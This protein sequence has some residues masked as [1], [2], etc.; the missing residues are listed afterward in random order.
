MRLDKRYKIELLGRISPDKG[1]FESVKGVKSAE[2]NGEENYLSLSIE[3]RGL[4]SA[5]EIVREL[6]A[7]I[8][9]IGGDI[10][11]KEISRPL[12]NLNCAAC[13][14][15]AQ[16]TL[17]HLPGVIGASVNY[18]NGKANIKY[19]P[20]IV[21]PS[22]IKRVL[23]QMGYELLI[24]EG[25]ASFQNVEQIKEKGY[26]KLRR[27]TI[28]AALFAIPLVI[29]GMFLKDMAHA[30][31]IM[32]LLS[33]P[34][35]LF[36]GRRFFVGALKQAKNRTANMDTLVA[37]STGIA[38]LFSLFNMLCPQFWEQKGLEA[39]VYFEAA[40]VII[41]FILLGRLLEAKATGSTSDAI[42]KLM[43][44]QPS[45][46]VVLRDDNPVEIAISEVLV[47][48]VVLVKPGEK[49][50]LDG[51]VIE[52]GSFVDES[53][54][55]GEPIHVEKGVGDKVYAGTI[56]Q[57]GSFSFRAKKVGEETLLAQIIK[58]VDEA[59]SSKAP[60]QGMVDKIAAI[61]VPSVIIIALISFTVWAIF[62]GENGFVYGLLAMVTVL[63][64]A[65]PCAL[66]LAT[67]TAVMVGIGKGAEEGVLI[68]DAESLEM[69][70]DIDM[71]ILDKTGT[72][73]EGKPQVTSITWVA[74]ALPLYS[75]IL[76]SIEYRSEHPL[77]D[78]ICADLKENSTLLNDIFVEQVSGKGITGRYDETHYYIGN[79][80]YIA[81]KNISIPEELQKK[82]E[83][84]LEAAHTVSIFADEKEAFAV[85]AITDKIKPGSK[86]AIEQLRSDGI[87]LAIYTGDNEKV[88]VALARELGIT[89][90][91]GGVLP[92]EKSEMVKMFQQQGRKVAMV[93]DG[94]N[95]SA[96]LAQADVSIA[97]G[98]G[99]DIAMD[100]AKM[101]IISSDLKKIP[102][103]I[104]LSKLTVRTIRQNLFWAFI[105]N[106]IGIPI[107]AGIL[108]PLTGFLLNP[109]IA[110]AAMALSS[111]S[112][113]TNSLR[114]RRKKI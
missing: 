30:N 31:L 3:E 63:V 33:T 97:M 72:I 15:G 17:L 91:K 105:Y 46:V 43:G 110:G 16:N 92:E 9:K 93:G 44:L 42:K 82:I 98:A 35:L 68:K 60:V 64:I 73:T 50:A 32:F 57:K 103:A 99:S 74:D 5:A 70:K 61:F 85:V 22:E 38:Y 107:A 54:I 20:T 21:A 69:A 90:F 12:L 10:V 87:D 104:H 67:P 51:E 1:L 84:E 41:A 108:Y 4:E 40:G 56:N 81:S 48:D 47:D 65:C 77:A 109:M 76:Y 55:S 95:D 49:I 89:T 102:K 52:G 26:K 28:W 71:V 27:D 45:S 34:I 11:A 53:M 100:V 101:T 94:I 106:L 7:A 24:D 79:E 66:G 58:T 59:Q 88:A 13:A 113:V 6:V 8:R 25:D 19:I 86:E 2:Y 36:F 83:E 114:L 80:Q 112:V 111:L 29:I 37:L 96:A 62:G 75:D 78:A 18:A 39:H 23:Q 14:A